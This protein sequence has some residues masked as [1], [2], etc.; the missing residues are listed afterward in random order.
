M[1]TVSF[2]H[3]THRFPTSENPSIEDFSLDVGDGE[4]MVLLGEAGSGKTT[5]LRLLH[6]LEEAASGAIF[7]GGTDVTRVNSRDRDVAIAFENYALYPHLSV[8]GN[9]GFALKLRGYSPEEIDARVRQA[10]DYL[11]LADVLD[12]TPDDLSRVLR[13][14]VALGRAIVRR[15]KVLLMDEPLA[16]MPEAERTLVRD[17]IRDL[18][19]A[20]GVTMLYATKDRDDAA[21]LGDRVAYLS[22]GTLQEVSQR[23]EDKARP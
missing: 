21:I 18:Q 11:D 6:G 10:A 1:A 22:E 20:L 19:A 16:Q 15:P 9:M 7:I 12:S 4:V 3:V 13:Q 17:Q 2:S 23:S 14:R 5:L 8:A